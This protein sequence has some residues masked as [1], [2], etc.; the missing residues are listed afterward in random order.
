M[1]DSDSSV[2]NE[3]KREKKG[4]SNF[5]SYKANIIK[6]QKLKAYHTQIILV[7]N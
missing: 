3:K 7:K 2:E 1:S 4:V 6:K 5:E